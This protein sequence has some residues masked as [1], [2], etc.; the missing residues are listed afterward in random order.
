MQSQVGRFLRASVWSLFVILS[1]GCA[2]SSS[3]PTAS[4]TSELV[5]RWFP[6]PK[7]S[8]YTL[9][10]RG[11]DGSIVSREVLAPT[12]CTNSL[13]EGFTSGVCSATISKDK[14]GN[15]QKIEIQASNTTVDGRQVPAR[16][17]K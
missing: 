13:V 6:V 10:V 14:V 17:V 5:I 11:E 16:I 15:K 1:V 9:L 4:D 8:G 7:A 2:K 3:A 12:G